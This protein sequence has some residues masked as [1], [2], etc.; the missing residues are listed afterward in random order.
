M[1]N[2]VSWANGI[3]SNVFLLS[4]E[5]ISACDSLQTW[6]SNSAT[7][8][9]FQSLYH[10]HFAL[11]ALGLLSIFIHI[12][13]VDSILTC[14]LNINCHRGDKEVDIWDEI[15]RLVVLDSMT[16]FTE[17]AQ[18]CSLVRFDSGATIFCMATWSLW[19]TPDRGTKER[20]TCWRKGL[21]K[22]ITAASGGAWQLSNSAD[23]VI[24]SDF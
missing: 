15:R 22:S 21:D 4:S 3:R 14:A 24:C 20:I 13:S 11:K 2:N 17:A 1:L 9:I 7:R 5:L 19:Q 18:L 16:I 23:K 10:R 12:S 8:V 6:G